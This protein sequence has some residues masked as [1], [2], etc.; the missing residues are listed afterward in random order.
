MQAGTRDLEKKEVA[1][2]RSW[3][4]AREPVDTVPQMRLPR[5]SK[6]GSVAT[7]QSCAR[8]RCNDDLGCPYVYVQYLVTTYITS[9]GRPF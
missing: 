8:L 3:T 7:F 4:L 5:A 6:K 9:C 2:Y 1:S